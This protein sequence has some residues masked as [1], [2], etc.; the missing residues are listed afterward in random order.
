MVNK[1]VI[2]LVMILCLG[3]YDS[4]TSYFTVSKEKNQI[5][6]KIELNRAAFENSYTGWG[7]STYAD[8][9]ERRTL[10]KKYVDDHFAMTINS[11]PMHVESFDVSFN[12]HYVIVEIQYR[13]KIQDT[14]QVHIK[15]TF[16]ITEYEDYINIVSAAIN[17]KVRGFRMTKNQQS[18]HFSY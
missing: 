2:A 1:I 14:G 17:E 9:K 15:N 10:I 6:L 8:D 13:E 4:K 7:A 16:M 12:H 18:I 5:H 3:R 11:K